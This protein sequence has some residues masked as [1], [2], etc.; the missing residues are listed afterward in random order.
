MDEPDA[1]L[2]AANRAH[3]AGAIAAHRAEGGIAVIA[4]HG[5]IEVESAAD[6]LELAA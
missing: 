3:L 4:T 6:V 1:G 2:D 5:D